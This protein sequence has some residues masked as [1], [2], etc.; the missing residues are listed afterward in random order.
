M[1]YPTDTTLI[2]RTSSKSDS[3]RVTIPQWVVRQ[4][5]LKAGHKMR[6]ELEPDGDEFKLVIQPLNRGGTEKHTRRLH[7][8][9]N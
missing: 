3:L 1:A 9:D 5:K 6:W 7:K 4:M 8:E 2:V